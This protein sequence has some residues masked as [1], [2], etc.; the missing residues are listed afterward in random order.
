MLK[1]IEKYWIML[2]HENNYN[3]IIEIKLSQSL[4]IEITL[5]NSF[6]FMYLMHGN[7]YRWVYIGPIKSWHIMAYF[8]IQWHNDSI[9]LL[10]NIM[11]Y[12]LNCSYVIVHTNVS[13][14]VIVS[15]AIEDLNTLLMH[16]VYSVN[17][18]SILFHISSFIF[19]DFL[20]LY[21]FNKLHNLLYLDAL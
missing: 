11:A 1:Y 19:S 3:F 18:S 15:F 9:F 4:I 12:T 20:V 13:Y 2:L 16:F 14:H 21:T 7:N 6:L 5:L 8:D 17:I 10:W